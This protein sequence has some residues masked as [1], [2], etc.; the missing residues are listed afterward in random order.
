MSSSAV[1]FSF[2]LHISALAAEVTLCISLRSNRAES[3]VVY[4]GLALGGLEAACNQFPSQVPSVV[5]LIFS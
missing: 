1:S 3:M 4:C 5:P 2:P